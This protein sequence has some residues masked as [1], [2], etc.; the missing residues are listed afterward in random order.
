MPKVFDGP[1]NSQM[2]FAAAGPNG[3]PASGLAV[4]EYIKGRMGVGYTVEN[5]TVHLFFA[6][7]AARDKYMENPEDPERQKLILD[8]ITLGSH[9]YLQADLEYIKKMT[10]REEGVVAD[11]Y[12]MHEMYDEV[13]SYALSTAQIEGII[14]LIL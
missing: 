12:A 1:I 7:E 3:E 6:D 14:N 8:R 5:G 4:Q 11:A 9:G 10:K 2:D 13:K